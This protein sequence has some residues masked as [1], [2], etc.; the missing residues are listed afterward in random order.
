M[1]IDHGDGDADCFRTTEWFDV[2]RGSPAEMTVATAFIVRF[3]SQLQN[4]NRFTNHVL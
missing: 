1:I 2:E 3:G 4:S